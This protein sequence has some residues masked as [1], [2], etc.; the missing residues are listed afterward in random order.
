M[1]TTTVLCRRYPAVKQNDKEKAMNKIY[2]DALVTTVSWEERENTYR[3]DSTD[4][5]FLKTKQNKKISENKA[6]NLL[7]AN[8]HW[9]LKA[10]LQLIFWV[11]S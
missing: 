1:P 5:K 2:K 11:L 8:I 7:I 10:K 9:K 3:L 4:K 6:K